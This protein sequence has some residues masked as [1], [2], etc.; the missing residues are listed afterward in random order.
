M[1]IWFLLQLYVIPILTYC[2]YNKGQR[3]N[4]TWDEPTADDQEQ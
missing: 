2:S 3:S 1:G 4:L